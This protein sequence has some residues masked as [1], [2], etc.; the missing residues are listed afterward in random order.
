MMLGEVMVKGAIELRKPEVTRYF[1]RL[2]QRILGKSWAQCVGEPTVVRKFMENYSTDQVRMLARSFAIPGDHQNQTSSG[3]M[4]HRKKG[5][6]GVVFM[7]P[8]NHD[9]SWFYG[10]LQYACNT[11]AQA[12]RDV[13]KSVVVKARPPLAPFFNTHSQSCS[14]NRSTC[15]RRKYL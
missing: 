5:K 2:N 11:A 15:W 12:W 10:S 9:D 7:D 6:E 13:K 8:T 3:T 14:T 1:G 4:A